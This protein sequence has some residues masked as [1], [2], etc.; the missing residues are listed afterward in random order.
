MLPS[1]SARAFSLPAFVALFLSAS[2]NFASPSPRAK[3]SK[4][5]GASIDVP[6]PIGHEAKGLVLPDYDVD[7]KLRV[8]FEAGTARRSSQDEIEFHDLKVTTYENDQL[9]LEIQMARSTLDLN[10]RVL[11]SPGRTTIKRR[12]FDI[13]GDS[14]HFN[15]QSKQSTL[16]GNVKMVLKDSSTL[17]PQKK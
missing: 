1:R 5:P 4:S 11:N 13:V 9:E 12:D 16:T 7:G 3:G 17:A 8:R 15:T 2:V 10:T 6:L 14:A